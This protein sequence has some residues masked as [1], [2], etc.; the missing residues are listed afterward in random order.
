[1]DER[2]NVD[3]SSS[4]W[5]HAENQ[6]KHYRTKGEVSLLLFLCIMKKDK[7]TQCKDAFKCMIFFRFSCKRNDITNKPTSKKRKK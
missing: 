6:M 4:V 2:H 1:M 7:E 5:V 3:G